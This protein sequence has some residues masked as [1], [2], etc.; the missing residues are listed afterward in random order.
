MDTSWL[1]LES[2][3][4]RAIIIEWIILV[5]YALE[6][7]AEFLCHQIHVVSPDLISIESKRYRAMNSLPAVVFT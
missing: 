7:A 1:Y 4:P 2:E 3:D 5:R 6:V